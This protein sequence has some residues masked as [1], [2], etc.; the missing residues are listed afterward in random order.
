MVKVRQKAKIADLG[1]DNDDV[2]GALKS[3]SLAEAF[4][5][6]KRKTALVDVTP[7]FLAKIMRESRTSV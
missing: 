1:V 3:A 5:Y 2:A 4:G 7:R 6:K